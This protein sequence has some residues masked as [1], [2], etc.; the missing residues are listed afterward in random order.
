MH[1]QIDEKTVIRS[2]R[3]DETGLILQFIKELALYEMMLD[4]VTATE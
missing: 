4:E 1:Y 3:E 2:A